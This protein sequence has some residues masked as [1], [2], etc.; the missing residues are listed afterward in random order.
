MSTMEGN[1]YEGQDVGYSASSDLGMLKYVG[2]QAKLVVVSQWRVGCEILKCVCL[3]ERVLSDSRRT[4]HREAVS[5]G[6]VQLVLTK[7]LLPY[8]TIQE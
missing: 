4:L 5:V 8:C 1:K 6:C 2:N 7:A 3:C